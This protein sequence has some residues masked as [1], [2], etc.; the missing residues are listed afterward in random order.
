MPWLGSILCSEFRTEKYFE[1]PDP[2]FN[3][4]RY[5]WTWIPFGKTASSKPVVTHTE[6]GRGVVS[7]PAVMG[8]ESE[9]ALVTVAAPNV[10]P[11][12]G[13]SIVDP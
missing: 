10:M 8:T 6:T 3:L 1:I 9:V 12:M 4:R 7:A 11:G 2:G 5:Y 13:F